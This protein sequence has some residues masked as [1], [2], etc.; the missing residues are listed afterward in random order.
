MTAGIPIM[1][2]I[3]SRDQ[4]AGQK[5]NLKVTNRS[6]VIDA[7]QTSK[8]FKNKRSDRAGKKCVSA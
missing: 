3:E 7:I 8:P 5:P 2:E 4:Y 6:I 1:Y